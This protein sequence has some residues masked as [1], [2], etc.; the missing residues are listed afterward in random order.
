VSHVARIAAALS[1]GRA[2]DDRGHF[3]GHVELYCENPDC[4]S[5][6][7]TIHFKE[8]DDPL[9]PRLCCPA[10]RRQLKLHHVWTLDEHE[11]EHEREARRRVNAQL[12]RRAHPDAIAMPLG[13]LLDERLPGPES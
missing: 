12:W 5:R 9:P 4:A 1:A 2:R 13:A 7:V 8:I 10:C 11:R 3:I 6:E